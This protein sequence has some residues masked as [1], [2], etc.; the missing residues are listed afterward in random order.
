M[1]SGGILQTLDAEAKGLGRVS[2]NPWEAWDLDA[3]GCP[4]PAS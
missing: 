2:L 1:T 4:A 3:G